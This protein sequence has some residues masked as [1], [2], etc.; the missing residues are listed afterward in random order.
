MEGHRAGKTLYLLYI[1]VKNRRYENGNAAQRNTSLLLWHQRLGHVDYRNIQN[2]AKDQMFKGLN[3]AADAMI[4]SDLCPGCIYGK[5]KRMPFKIERTRGTCERFCLFRCLWP[6]ADS[7]GYFTGYIDTRRSTSGLLFLRHGGPISWK[8]KRQRCVT[9]SMTEAEYVAASEATREAV[10]LK[11][12]LDEIDYDQPKTILLNCD[13]QSTVCLVW[14]P[15]FHQRTKHIETKYHFIR[16]R[17]QQGGIEIKYIDTH[18]QLADIFTKPLPGPHFAFLR[19][20][21]G[22]GPI[23]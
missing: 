18:N 15:E 20:Q 16:E 2:M 1:L 4:P 17:Q 13:N 23:E 19:E 3:L 22:I 10:W 5:M 6:N 7:I 21:L 12:L 8:S 14:N 9:L 11:R